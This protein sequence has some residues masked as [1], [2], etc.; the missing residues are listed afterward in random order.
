MDR[1]RI[2]EPCESSNFKLVPEPTDE[3]KLTL[4]DGESRNHQ[5]RHYSLV[6]ATHSTKALVIISTD[7][8][9]RQI[10]DQL[11]HDNNYN[12]S[13]HIINIINV[14]WVLFDF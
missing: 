3:F 7:N 8:V 5:H 1:E 4:L 13:S 12:N 14:V 6:V 9:S 10:Q 11:E 2:E